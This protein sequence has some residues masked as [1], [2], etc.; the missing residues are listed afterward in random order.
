MISPA[1]STP[2]L[3]KDL[4]RFPGWL[5][6]ALLATSVA[7]TIGLLAF[8]YG[9]QP[10]RGDGVEYR[11]L[12]EIIVRQG[13]W[14][15]ASDLRTY[16]YPAFLALL[17]SLSGDDP[18]SF[19]RAVFV[20][21]LLIYIGAA[22]FAAI[23]ISRALGSAV[24]GVT[25]FAAMVLNP[26]PLF[27]CVQVLTDVLSTALILL[28]VV[29]SLPRCESRR[30]VIL[31][32]V[33]AFLLIGL[34]VMVRPANLIV[35]A[36]LILVWIIRARLFRDVPLAAVPALAAALAL[37]FLPQI[38]MNQRA[39]GVVQPL[40]VRNLY[41]E[42]L[43]NGMRHAKYVTLGISGLPN[44]AIYFNPFFPRDSE[45]LTVQQ[46]L[47]D[48]PAAYAATLA[49]HAFTLVDQDYPFTYVR[50]L[51]PWYRW[52]LSVFNYLFLAGAVVGLANGLR[53]RRDT[54]ETRRRW[55]VLATAAIVS[56]AIVTIYLP[57]EIEN[58]FS[59]P[60]YPLLT[61]PF[62]LATMG[63]W[64][65]RRPLKAAHVAAL[66]ALA[67][68]LG[69]AAALSIWLQEQSP[70][71][72][73]I[74]AHREL[75]SPEPPVAALSGEL[76]KEWGV[77]QP[78]VFVVEATNFGDQAWSSNG[79]YPVTVAVRFSSMK[80]IQHVALG[81][82]PRQYIRLPDDVPPNGSTTVVVE[83][84]APR[85]PGRYILEVQVFRHGVPDPDESL[86][87]IVRV[88]R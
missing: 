67:I 53:R 9:E 75:P 13:F 66:A 74:R 52:P 70:V 33:A 21:Q 46:M 18:T 47:R 54:P 7:C 17:L 49:L 48:H 87:R 24:P 51:D 79:F 59:L 69:A 12:A 22:T 81:P 61:A 82:I 28:A 36:A 2:T 27:H 26:F 5:A 1:T 3:S 55:F 30:R 14:Q 23:R 37:P 34:A 72:A 38:L 56:A 31:T 77:G 88:E 6:I 73:E 42:Q 50:D 11:R 76:P 19:R 71:L 64:R 40:I 65:R 32:G 60:L 25:I 62:L 57:T 41:A 68:W 44:R 29:L 78:Q 63:A 39:F 35:A 43:E 58:R 45:K 10:I 4:T 80:E 83:A 86:Q 8:A 15:F 85:M 16:G 20:A 84:V